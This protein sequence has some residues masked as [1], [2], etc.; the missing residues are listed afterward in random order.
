MRIQLFAM[1]FLPLPV[2]RRKCAGSGVR[3]KNR[4]QCRAIEKQ[5]EPDV[6]GRVTRGSPRIAPGRAGDG[7]KNPF[8]QS[9]LQYLFRRNRS[10]VPACWLSPAAGRRGLSGFVVCDL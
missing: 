6:G 1:Q 7:R 2:T 4:G 3:G 10:A 9:P 5:R 8:Q